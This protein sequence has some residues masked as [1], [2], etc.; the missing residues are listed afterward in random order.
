MSNKAKI[1][2]QVSY[3]SCENGGPEKFQVSKEW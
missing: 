3:R 1:N 2:L